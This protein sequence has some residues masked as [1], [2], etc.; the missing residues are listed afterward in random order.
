MEQSGKFLYYDP[1][2]ICKIIHSYSYG[3]KITYYIICNLCVKKGEN[4]PDIPGKCPDIT[5]TK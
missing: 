3:L 2:F 5:G 4:G 1:H